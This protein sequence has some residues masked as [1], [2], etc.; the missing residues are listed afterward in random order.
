MIAQR[1]APCWWNGKQF[2]LFS[3]QISFKKMFA[4]KGA[5]KPLFFAVLSSD[6]KQ[7]F[8][9][10]K[11]VCNIHYSSSL[12]YLIVV[13]WLYIS[14]K[15]FILFKVT[16]K[17][18]SA[19]SSKQDDCYIV[20]LKVQYRSSHFWIFWKALSLD[21]WPRGKKIIFKSKNLYNLLI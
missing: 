18:N 10:C 8:L 14:C 6:W 7:T 1:P 13:N 11:K 12:P 5:P 21:Y 4:A 20:L 2:L 9:S 3:G 15:V 16:K 17:K 19:D